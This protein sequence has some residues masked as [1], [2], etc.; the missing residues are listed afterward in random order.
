LTQAP[1]WGMLERVQ[2][3]LLALRANVRLGLKCLVVTNAL[4]YYTS[5]KGFRVAT[6]EVNL[7][8]ILD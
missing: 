7:K 2:G 6:P 4:A 3:K 8:T 1:L 5:V